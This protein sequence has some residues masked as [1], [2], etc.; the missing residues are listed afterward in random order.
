MA[1]PLQ[2]IDRRDLHVPDCPMKEIVQYDCVVKSTE[3][4]CTPITRQFKV[5]PNQM[6]EV[7][8]VQDLTREMLAIANLNS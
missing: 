4:V 8:K 3:V 5:C 1:P 2:I 6:Y 7:S